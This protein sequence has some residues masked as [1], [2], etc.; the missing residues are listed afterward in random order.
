MH[1]P[2]CSVMIG[3]NLIA[4]NVVSVNASF[5]QPTILEWQG[6]LECDGD[7]EFS[8]GAE[9]LSYGEGLKAHLLRFAASDLTPGKKLSV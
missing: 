1:A 3:E 9:E 8:C 5:T 4:P 2:S 7:F 6:K